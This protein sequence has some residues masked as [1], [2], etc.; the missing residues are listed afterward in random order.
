MVANVPHPGGA[1]HGA[2]KATR[3]RRIT[4]KDEVITVMVLRA[5]EFMAE[6]KTIPNELKAMQ[7]LVGGG[8]FEII[9]GEYMLPPALQNSVLA[10][11]DIFVNEEGI[12]RGLEPNI[13][14][15]PEAALE[16]NYSNAGLLFGDI[17]I[18]GHDTEGD[19][20]SI[21]RFDIM[22]LRWLLARHMLINKARKEAMQHD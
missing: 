9:R 13:C 3:R 20:V 5:G 14:L 16:K 6:V 4:M 1:H 17:F 10:K 21:D 12:R 19:T 7:E 15:N 8:Y 2:I 11:Y 18:A 22:P